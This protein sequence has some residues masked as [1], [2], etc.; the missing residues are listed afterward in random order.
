MGICLAAST[1]SDE[2]IRTLLADPPRVW[3]V[4]EPES[5]ELYLDAIGR[6]KPPG[7]LARLLGDRRPWPPEVPSFTFEPGER[8]ELD[9]DKAWDGVNFCLKK[10]VDA[11]ACPNFFED[12]T[13]V[14]KV[15]VGYGP[16]GCF[17]SVATARI[18][19]AYGAVSRDALMAQFAPEEMRDVYLSGLWEQDNDDARGYLEDNFL[20]LQ[21]FLRQAEGHK[22]GVLV[23][24]T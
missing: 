5:E 6:A 14:G 20:E 7:W 24:F 22:M 4:I 18:A 15:E 11:D 19:R 16:A 17:D 1:L 8:L 23:Y 12:G 10:L 2:K 13:P 3:R 9:M 21:E